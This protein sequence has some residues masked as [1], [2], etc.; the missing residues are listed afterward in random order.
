MQKLL[1]LKKTIQVLSVINGLSTV[2]LG[3]FLTFA[4]GIGD[5]VNELSYNAIWAIM[6]IAMPCTIG[7]FYFGLAYL[8]M[9]IGLGLFWKKG[10]KLASGIVLVFSS[11]QIIGLLIVQVLFYSYDVT[12][13]ICTSSFLLPIAMDIFIIWLI[14]RFR[15]LTKETSVSR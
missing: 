6:H 7:V 15:K 11:A 9:A 4:F 3:F 13:V 8:V 5:P 2:F 1:Q 14:F 10:Y 12:N